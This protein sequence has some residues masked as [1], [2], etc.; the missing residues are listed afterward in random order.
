MEF[1]EKPK[2]S[3]RAYWVRITWHDKS[4]PPEL[5]EFKTN[6]IERTMEQWQRNRETFEWEVISYGDGDKT[7]HNIGWGP[8]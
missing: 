4:L 5:Q 7:V 1:E 8:L 3:N 6:D 2:R